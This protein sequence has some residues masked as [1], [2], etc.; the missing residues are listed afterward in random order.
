MGDVFERLA[1]RSKGWILGT[2]RETPAK[3]GGKPVDDHGGGLYPAIGTFS[4]RSI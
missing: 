1:G 4:S 2:A 3:P